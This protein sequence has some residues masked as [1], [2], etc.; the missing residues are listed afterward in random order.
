MKFTK[1]TLDKLKIG[2]SATV[3]EIN[4]KD[5]KR[6]RH[7][8][9]MGLTRG[10]QVKIK[11]IAP[12]GDP[13]S[14]EL[15][16]YELCIS[17]N[18][19]SQVIV[20]NGE[21]KTSVPKCEKIYL[22]SVPNGEKS[23]KTSVPFGDKYKICLVGNQ[24]SG[25]TTLFNCLTGMNQ[26]VGNW[27]GVTIERKTGIIK[28]TNHELVDLPGI[29]SLSPYSS[30]E[31]V[32]CDYILKEKP[33]VIINIVDST[34][35]ERSLYLTTQLLELDCK[36]IIALNMVDML[37]KKGLT[38]DI[39]QLE[40]DLNTKVCPISALKEIG[41]DDLIE[42]ID[43]PDIRTQK[44]IITYKSN[45]EN[46]YKEDLEE[47][48]ATQRYDFISNIKSRC[49]KQKKKWITTTQLL[50]K[51]FLSKIF[52]IPI[53]IIIMFSI[54]FLSVGVVGKYTSGIIEN[55]IEQ[56]SDIASNILQNIGVSE[57]LQ[58]LVVNG[59]IT[60]VS[61]VLSFVPQLAI[62]FLCISILETTGYMSRIAFLLDKIFRKIGL[63]GKSLIPFIVGSGCSVP[64]I[65]STKIIEN[66]DERKMT[67]ILVPFIPCSA[68]LP[69]IALFSG[70]FFKSNSGFVSGSLYFLSISV[71]ILSAIIMKKYVF[72]NTTSTFISE[73]PD[74]KLPNIKYVFNDVIEKTMSFIK[75]AGSTILVASIVIWFLISFSM[76]LKYGVE[77]ENSILATI[78]KKISWIFV[79]MLGVNSWEA[80]VSAIQGLI[81]KEQVISSMAIISGNGSIF[82]RQSVF[83]FFNTISAYSFVVFNLFSAPC[84]AAIAA[85]KKELGGFRKMLMAI[86]YQTVLAWCLA[87]IIYNIFYCI[88]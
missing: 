39:H 57:W 26:K 53:F 30:E 44:Y 87:S 72:I 18:E 51:I 5:K 10:T 55:I 77:I 28:N 58:S 34:C 22:T 31:K 24:N 42:E 1:T 68:K 43:K 2:Q 54:Y 17:K 73:L 40:A 71:I 69:I 13:I 20:R 7:L 19:L 84:F 9:D 11:K 12:M 74:Y 21:V 35:I 4:I 64:G 61:S 47:E 78:G 16:G 38:I 25:K 85:M 60:G 27:P 82:A 52:A 6:K 36:V 32:S 45:L 65:M 81:A 23:P 50:D 29:Y 3:I 75:R 14:I 46:S 33:D 49:I 8:L 76:D 88:F 56:F 80:T 70:Y 67:S 79:P 62:L 48:I 59:I 15:R 83:G 41:I 86:T 66:E 37:K 63:S